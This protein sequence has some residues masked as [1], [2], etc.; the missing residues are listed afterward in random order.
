M[1]AEAYGKVE[2]VEEGLTLLAE[3]FTQMDKTGER[4]YEA[5]LYRLTGS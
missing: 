2:Q 4:V 3:A 1:L 5:E